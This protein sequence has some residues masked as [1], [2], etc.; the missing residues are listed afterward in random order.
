M[1]LALLALRLCKRRR[2][3][4]KIRRHEDELVTIDALGPQPDVLATAG[5]AEQGGAKQGKADVLGWVALCLL[6]WSVIRC[7]VRQPQHGMLLLLCQR[8]RE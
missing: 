4:N 2:H 5:V 3:A 7:V 8:R 6:L 1:L